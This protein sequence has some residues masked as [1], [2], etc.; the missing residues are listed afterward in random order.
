MVTLVTGYNT[1]VDIRYK[2][3]FK[4]MDKEDMVHAG[5]GRGVIGVYGVGL[6]TSLNGVPPV[7]EELAEVGYTG[8][9]RKEAML[10][11]R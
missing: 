4:F 10:T 5:K 9:V 2:G 6:S 11:G 1:E 3:C 8:P 7:F